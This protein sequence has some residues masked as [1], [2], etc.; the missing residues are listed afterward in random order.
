MDTG[1]SILVR[2]AIE[3]DD[4]QIARL[5]DDARMGPLSDRGVVFVAADAH[6]P[7]RLLGFVRIVEAE[8]SFYVNP[9]VVAAD[10]R[11]RGVGRLLM[12]HM[13]A[14]FGRLLFVARGEAV[15]FYE[16]LGC[17]PVSWNVIAPLIAEDCNGCVER[18]SCCPQPMASDAAPLT[19]AVSE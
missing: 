7:E 1:Q 4:G 2:E 16:A 18:A 17:A 12:E 14:R 9:I 3:A 6:D 13:R 19:Q 5:A 8:G 15:P 11:G 10:G